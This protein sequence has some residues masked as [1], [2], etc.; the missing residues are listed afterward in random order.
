[1]TFFFCNCSDYI[2]PVTTY[3]IFRINITIQIES[4]CSHKQQ[5]I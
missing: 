2:D 3:K 1:M 4:E 5:P